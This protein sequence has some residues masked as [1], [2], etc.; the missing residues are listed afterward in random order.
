MGYRVRLDSR[1]SAATRIE[2]VTEGILTRRLQ[3]DPELSGVGLVI[4]DEIHE[5]SLQADLAL[6]LCREVQQ[7]LR[8]DLRLLAMS[9]TLEVEPLQR[10]LDG[11]PLVSGGSAM[12]PVE[13]RYLERDPLDPVAETLVRGVLRALEQAPGDVLAFLPGEAEIRRAQELLADAAREQDLQIC[14]LFGNLG[15][16]AQQAALRPR[17]DG[18]RRVVL[19]TD[20]AETSLTIEGV[21]SV[22]DGGWARAPRFDPATALTRLETLRVSRAA[23]DQRAGRAGRL[24]PGLCLRLWSEALQARLPARADPEILSADLAGL[25]LEL[26]CWGVSDP[27]G[28]AWMDGPPAAAYAQA[29]DLLASLDALDREGRVTPQ[30]RRM[31]ELGLHPR[32]AHMVLEGERL[33]CRGLAADLAALLSERDPFPRGATPGRSVDLAERLRLLALWRRE[34]AGPV[35]A[36]QGDPA[37]CARIHKL[38][39]Q[40][41]GGSAAAGCSAGALL[42]A[43]YPDRVGRRRDASTPVY[44]LASGGAARLPEDDPLRGAELIVAPVVQARGAE[45]RIHLAAPITL[46]EVRQV[47]GAHLERVASVRWDERSAAVSAVH[48]ERLGPLVLERRP[49]HAPDPASVARAL[50]EGIRRGG[51]AALP[52]T[53]QARALQARLLCLRDWLPQGHWPDVSGRVLLD[54]LDDW[55]LPWVGSMTRLE[56]LRR[57][58]LEQMLRA[59]LDWDHQQAL[60]R[61]APE[62]IQVP[63]GSRRPLQYRP[64]GPPVLAVRLQELFGLARTPCVCAGRVPV[65]LHILSP[66]QRP[67][68]VTQ[69]LAGFWE[70]TYPEVKKELK[71]RYPKHHWPEDPWQAIPTAG[72]RPRPRD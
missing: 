54:T 60:E 10:V 49:L 55:L 18:G 71:G 30:G 16:E 67:I 4:F 46:A 43:A 34:G 52:W 21:R 64:G 40:L 63:S 5:R 2:V 65:L 29:R 8:A 20:I 27:T 33:G 9:A 25:V 13:I 12:H 56:Q 31:A 70:R 28:L 61:L 36:A 47:L 48:E 3:R 24:G 45:G 72:V 35:R 22:V 11:A 14:P 37:A 38:A 59:R 58:S 69:D 41:G 32:L 57:L 50:I 1:V 39:K 51:L 15:Q 44:R 62:R 19:A 17:S 23:A 66:A 68:Q 26:A 7:G 42:A 53:D 6:A